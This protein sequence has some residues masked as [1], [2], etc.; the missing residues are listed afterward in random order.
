RRPGRLRRGVAPG[1]GVR[2]AQLRRPALRLGRGDPGHPPADR[3]ADGGAG[4]ARAPLPAARRPSAGPRAARLV[5]RVDR[6]ARPVTAQFTVEP[7]RQVYLGLDPNDGHKRC[8]A[9]P[10]DSVGIVGPPRYG[11]TSGLIVPAL[12]GWDGPAV[13]TST[14]GDLLAFCGGWRQ[15]LA[16]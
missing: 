8:W 1:A 14:R 6:G 16:S 3:A 13:V 10:E 9:G 15:R 7:R 5:G 11:K 12:M 2:A 4:A